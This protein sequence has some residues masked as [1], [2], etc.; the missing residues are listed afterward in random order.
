[1][2]RRITYIVLFL[3]ICL[4]A[5]LWLH[6]AWK[7]DKMF[8]ALSEAQ[9]GRDSNEL[10]QLFGEPMYVYEQFPAPLGMALISDEINDDDIELQCYLI[11]RFPPIFLVV[12]ANKETGSILAATLENS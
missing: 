2:T 1:M 8:R 4:A 7:R 10:H 12:K 5:A 6:G 9:Y 3:G 11:A